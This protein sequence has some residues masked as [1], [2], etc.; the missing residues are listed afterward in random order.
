MNTELIIRPVQVSDATELLEIYS[1]YV[2]RTAVTFEYTVPTLL[3]F[4]KRIERTASQYPYF[5]AQKGHAI[6]GYAYAGSFN[7]RKAY[8]WAVETSIYVKTEERKSGIGRQLY[9]SLEKCLAELHYL[10]MNACIAFGESDDPYLTSDSIAF[11]KGLGFQQVGRFHSCG[12]KFGKWYDMI[13]MEKHIG[14]HTA[15]PL[16]VQPFCSKL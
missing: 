3:E 10:N 13:W 6:V 14:E 9:V 8:D 4:E 12:Y 7:S 11:H 5:V 1:P 15:S 16:P 2:E